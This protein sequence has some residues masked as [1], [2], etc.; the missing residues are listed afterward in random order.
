MELELSQ[1]L[2]LLIFPFLFK[3]Q[4]F[5]KVFFSLSVSNILALPY[6][7]HI[8]V[9]SFLMEQDAKCN[10]LFFINSIFPYL[11]SPNL[12]L[13]QLIIFSF[14]YSNH[15]KYCHLNQNQMTK[16]YFY[17]QQDFLSRID[18][19]LFNYQLL[20]LKPNPTI[21]YLVF[22]DLLIHFTFPPVYYF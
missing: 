14:L 6:L 13:Y 19:F 2:L 15:V 7:N 1:I 21:Q 11:S 8:L 22:V 20:G 3:V 9:F 5:S 4:Q 18:H 16:Y 12:L 17:F 10:E